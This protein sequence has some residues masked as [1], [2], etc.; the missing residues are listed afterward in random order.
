MGKTNL[1]VGEETIKAYLRKKH[2]KKELEELIFRPFAVIYI[3]EPN[4]GLNGLLITSPVPGTFTDKEENAIFFYSEDGFKIL[5]MDLLRVF[6]QFIV[7]SSED[8]NVDT[9]KEGINMFEAIFKNLEMSN[10]FIDRTKL[11]PHNLN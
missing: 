8:R 11:N 5:F 6:A 2:L 4:T 7:K 9:L 3:T 1:L 10:E